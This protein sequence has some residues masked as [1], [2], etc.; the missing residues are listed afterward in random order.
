LSVKAVLDESL[1]TAEHEGNSEWQYQKDEC[2]SVF[3]HNAVGLDRVS[4][5]TSQLIQRSKTRSAD[6]KGHVSTLS[7]NFL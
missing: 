2:P 5:L 1:H 4:L 3:S 6:I 7:H